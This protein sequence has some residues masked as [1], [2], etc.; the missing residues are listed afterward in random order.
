M[1]SKPVMIVGKTA[2]TVL[3]A[4]ARV[5]VNAAATRLLAHKPSVLADDVSES[6]E[7]A[8]N[9]RKADPDEDDNEWD[10]A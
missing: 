6:L 2:Q 1:N 4:G 5:G 10:A 8:K 3:V 7:R 9:R